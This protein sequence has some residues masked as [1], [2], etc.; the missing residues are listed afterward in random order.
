MTWF[1]DISDEVAS[2]RGW[3]YDTGLGSFVHDNAPVAKRTIE[4]NI[5]ENPFIIQKPPKGSKNHCFIV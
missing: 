5:L 4:H 3:L 1:S 2:I